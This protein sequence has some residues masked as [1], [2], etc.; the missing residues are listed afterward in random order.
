[1]NSLSIRIVPLFGSE[2]ALS[3]TR[4]VLL[5]PILAARCT[6]DGGVGVT[7]AP[8]LDA[9]AVRVAAPGVLGVATAAGDKHTPTGQG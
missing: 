8:V 6:C 3:T 7:V 9:V 1:M 5:A 4:L 2:L